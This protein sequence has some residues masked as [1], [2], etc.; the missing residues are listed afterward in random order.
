M[1]TISSSD[2]S[3]FENDCENYQIAII[4]RSNEI[5][6]NY[7]PKFNN[8]LFFFDYVI[9]PYLMIFSSTVCGTSTAQKETRVYTS[10]LINIY[11]NKKGSEF[12]T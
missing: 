3:D 9:Y 8:Y 12:N 11:Y 5:K 10:C 4:I 2:E 7:L 1:L 6:K